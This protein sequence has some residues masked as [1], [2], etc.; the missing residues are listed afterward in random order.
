MSDP[1]SRRP[2]QRLSRRRLIELSAQ[3][4]VADFDTLGLLGVHRLLTTGHIAGL[5]YGEASTRLAGDRAAQRALR[6]LE[7]EGVVVGLPRRVGGY[8]GGATQAVWRLTEAGQRLLRLQAQGGAGYGQV[9]GDAGRPRI[10]LAE[11]SPQFL[12]H[13]LRV[14][15]VRLAFERLRETTDG[16]AELSLVQTE[17]SCWRRWT[18]PHGT[19][20][21]LRPDLY[22]ETVSSEFVDCWFIEADLGTEHLPVVVRKAKVYEAYRRSG[23]EQAARGVF[24]LVLWVTPDTRRAEAILFAI[25]G[26]PGCD[27]RAHRAVSFDQLSDV[28]ANGAGPEPIGDG[29]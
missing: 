21:T 12:A 18:G 26:D 19:P 24:P 14:A 2:V 23:R 4:T 13:T 25:R 10:R 28:L 1:N 20:A 9:D 27:G 17:P 15:D 29:A 7:H 8:G 16:K 6:K 22:A 5:M 11:P 3:L